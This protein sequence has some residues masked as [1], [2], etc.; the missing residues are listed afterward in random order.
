MRRPLVQVRTMRM[1]GSIATPVVRRRVQQSQGPLGDRE[2]V[3][4]LL[5]VTGTDPARG[6]RGGS[7]WPRIHA[8]N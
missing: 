8:G 5:R 1:V 3:L 2:A 4:G 7:G 6:V